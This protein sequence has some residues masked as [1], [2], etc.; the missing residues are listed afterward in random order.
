MAYPSGLDVR[1]LES[2]LCCLL[3]VLCYGAGMCRP[4]FPRPELISILNWK[5]E[6]QILLNLFPGR[7]SCYVTDGL[8]M[9]MEY[10]FEFPLTPV[11]VSIVTNSGV[12]PRPVCVS[13]TV[14]II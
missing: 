7:G 8:N 13:A 4:G 10:K 11:E 2:S 9:S 5:T 6:L 3:R 1:L 12:L 14:V